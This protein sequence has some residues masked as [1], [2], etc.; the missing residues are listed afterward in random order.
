MYFFLVKAEAVKTWE[1]RKKTFSFFFLLFCK[2]GKPSTKTNAHRKG[3]N[4]IMRGVQ[5]LVASSFNE[6]MT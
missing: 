2:R 5:V 1:G 4:R 3:K 6:A